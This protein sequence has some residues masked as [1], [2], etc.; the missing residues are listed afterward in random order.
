MLL[1]GK[2]RGG[3]TWGTNQDAGSE[4]ADAVKQRVSGMGTP[5]AFAGCAGR[6]G[7]WVVAG[8]CLRRGQRASG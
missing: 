1:W 2:C 5:R 4:A 8:E 6:A 7:P 3:T